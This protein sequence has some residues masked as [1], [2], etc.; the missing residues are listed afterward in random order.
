MSAR[1]HAPKL[2]FLFAL[3]GKFKMTQRTLNSVILLHFRCS[4]LHMAITYNYGATQHFAISSRF[5]LSYCMAILGYFITVQCMLGCKLL[6]K[7]MCYLHNHMNKPIISLHLQNQMKEC[8]EYIG[9][10]I[11]Q[12]ICSLII[13]LKRF[14]MLVMALISSSYLH[15][16]CVCILSW[17]LHVHG[18]FIV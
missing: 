16:V 10:L 15:V 2:I 4:F 11:K 5:H 9:L 1:L 7:I 18:K 12:R 6:H 14:Q 3:I 17:E 13:I 8:Y